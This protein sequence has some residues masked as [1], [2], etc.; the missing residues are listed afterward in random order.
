MGSRMPDLVADTTIYFVTQRRSH[1][2][3]YRRARLVRRPRRDR[4]SIPVVVLTVVFLIG[5][6]LRTVHATGLVTVF[7]VWLHPNVDPLF[8]TRVACTALGAVLLRT[9]LATP[10]VI[11]ALPVRLLRGN[12]AT[13]EAGGSLDG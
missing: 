2:V 1:V 3:S 11:A 6:V 10:S 4:L 8:A 12:R 5:V 9:T 13:D 7:G